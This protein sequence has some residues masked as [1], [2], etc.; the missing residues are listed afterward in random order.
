VTEAT[1]PRAR[2]LAL[3]AAAF[4]LMLVAATA[5]VAASLGSLQ[6]TRVLWVSSGLSCASILFALLAV[7]VP[8]GS[9]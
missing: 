6:S 8:R 5:L 1:P 4:V 2:H 7:V 9:E 3:Y